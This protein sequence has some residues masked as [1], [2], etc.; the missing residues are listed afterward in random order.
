MQYVT[1]VLAFNGNTVGVNVPLTIG[2]VLAQ[3]GGYIIGATVSWF[4]IGGV[5]GANR[6]QVGMG[7]GIA[8]TQLIADFQG[9]GAGPAQYGD[10]NL[11]PPGSVNGGILIP[12]GAP[13]NINVN[14]V[15]QG[16]VQFTVTLTIWLP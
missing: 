1:S 10:I 3:A 6:L 11:R 13:N 7:A 14:G 8:L 2:N 9:Q 4:I 15:N 5:I 16:P 12:G